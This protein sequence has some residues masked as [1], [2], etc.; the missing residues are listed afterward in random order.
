M[1]LKQISK[2]VE[3]LKRT[4]VKCLESYLHG[5]RKI[6]ELERSEK[7]EKLFVCFICRHFGRSGNQVEKEMKNNCWP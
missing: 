4:I 3:K 1:L 2:L 6:I 7:A 5:G